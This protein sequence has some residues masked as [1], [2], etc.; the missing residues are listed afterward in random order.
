[1]LNPDENIRKAYAGKLSPIWEKRV[2]EDV[3][4]VPNKY[5]LISTQSKQPTERKKDCFEWQC[6][7]VIECIS[8]QELGYASSIPVNNMEA[9]VITAIE[10]GIEVE[11][12]DV[13]SYKFIGSVSLDTETQTNSIYR[14]VIT[15]EHWLAEK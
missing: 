15:Y 3:K 12:F 7:I 6:Q 4:P 9:A 14:R 13:K 5:Y 8:I 11:G 2:P 10:A 1:M